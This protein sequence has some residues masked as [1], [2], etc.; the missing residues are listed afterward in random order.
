MTSRHQSIVFTPTELTLVLLAAREQFVFGESADAAFLGDD[1]MAEQPTA[2][3]RLV[4]LPDP[5]LVV[6][7]LAVLD[8]AHDAADRAVPA[9]QPV[10]LDPARG[11]P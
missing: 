10:Q 5:G 8:E 2:L 1:G 3:A 9:R 4:E 11:Q 7:E 6:Q